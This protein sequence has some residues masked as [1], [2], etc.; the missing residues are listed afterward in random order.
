MGVADVAEVGAALRHGDKAVTCPHGGKVGG[1]IGQIGE[2]DRLGGAVGGVS[3]ACGC[4]TR[5]GA[6]GVSVVRFSHGAFAGR[7]ADS[8]GNGVAGRKGG[9]GIRAERRGHIQRLGRARPVESGGKFTERREGGGGDQKTGRCRENRLRPVKGGG[10]D[11]ERRLHSRKALRREGRR[12][13]RQGERGGGAGRQGVRLR[14]RG[15]PAERP[16]ALLARFLGVAAGMDTE[17]EEQGGEDDHRRRQHVDKIAC[18]PFHE[19]TSR[20]EK[21]R[22]RRGTV[23]VF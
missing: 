11:G 4:R 22:P 15:I 6:C 13:R 7:A 12:C 18:I 1:G 14:L 8:K 5:G 19:S 10:K 9:G 20:D 3:R 21:S 23:A 17:G 2:G 16:R